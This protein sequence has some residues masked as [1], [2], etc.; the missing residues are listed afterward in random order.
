MKNRSRSRK[1][2]LSSRKKTE[3]LVRELEATVKDFDKEVLNPETHAH[4]SIFRQCSSGMLLQIARMCMN[5]EVS[6]KI[7]KYIYQNNPKVRKRYKDSPGIKRDKD[8]IPLALATAVRK[9][10][11][12]VLTP[13]H[14]LPQFNVEAHIK[15]K[16]DVNID[17]LR[18]IQVMIAFQKERIS[19]AHGL[20]IKTGLHDPMIT[21]EVI[22]L[23]QL[24]LDHVRVC[25][26]LGI[27][28]YTA[29]K[30]EEIEKEY[31]RNINREIENSE[32]YLQLSKRLDEISKDPEIQ[33]WIL[34]KAMK[35]YP[36]DRSIR[37]DYKRDD[38]EG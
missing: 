17:A 22:V 21:K 15:S 11:V 8:G 18:E 34:A 13:L 10:R 37:P 27:E 33:R 20:E 25:Q 7:A 12:R 6:G 9:F 14:R 26:I 19:N 23:R 35:T 30:R 1:I 4:N 3:T 24:V 32:H 5:M 28:P 29:Y 31:Y 2:G 16:V 36:L 38:K